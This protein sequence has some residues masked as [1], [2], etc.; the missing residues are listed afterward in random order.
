MELKGQM[1]W[2]HCRFCRV[3]C[4]FFYPLKGHR[5]SGKAYLRDLE[6]HVDSRGHPGRGFQKLNR[7]VRSPTAGLLPG[8]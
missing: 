6:S 1:Q 5:L 8:M 3:T 7:V 4:G 2:T